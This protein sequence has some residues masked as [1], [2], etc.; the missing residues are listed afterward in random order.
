MS[1]YEWQPQSTTTSSGAPQSYIVNLE[2]V[3]LPWWRR[4]VRALS[5]LRGLRS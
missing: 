4:V 3:T 1:K 2:L 5:R